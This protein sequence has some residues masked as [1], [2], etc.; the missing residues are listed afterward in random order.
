[1]WLQCNM[2]TGP[3]MTP[4]LPGSYYNIGSLRPSSHNLQTPLPNISKWMWAH[5]QRTM[6]WKAVSKAQQWCGAM[7][8]RRHSKR[9]PKSFQKRRAT[10]K[11]GMKWLRGRSLSVELSEGPNPRDHKDN[12]RLTG[13]V[14]ACC[15]S[16]SDRKKSAVSVLIKSSSHKRAISRLSCS[17]RSCSWMPQE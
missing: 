7:W 12:L 16:V 3:A 4:Y 11:P 13:K 2:S 10:T 15:S 14:D 5:Q 8:T 17:L 1:M 9:R 6:V